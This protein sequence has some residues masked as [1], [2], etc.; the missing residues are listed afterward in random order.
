[1]E[2]EP[3]LTE[4][5]NI[6]L[7]PAGMG[8]SL[9]AARERLAMS[10][11]QAARALHLPKKIVIALEE[12]D[13]EALP[14]PA[15]VK[16]YLRAYARVLEI[17]EQRLIEQYLALG[18]RDPEL[19]VFMPR[20]EGAPNRI[21]VGL[22]AA[23]VALVSV[24]L[25]AVWWNTQQREFTEVA[26]VDEPTSEAGE[27]QTAE[28]AAS[29]EQLA[30]ARQRQ[31]E[32]EF[33]RGRTMRGGIAGHGEITQ[34]RDVA[35]SSNIAQN[36]DV[37]NG[38]DTPPP[39]GAPDTPR[40]DNATT[41]KPAQAPTSSVVATAA[42]DNSPPRPGSA[43]ATEAQSAEAA[44]T[45]QDKLG[46]RYRND[47]WTEVEDANGKQLL[48]GMV[49]AGE[50]HRVAGEAPFEVLLG[51]SRGV[52]LTINGEAFDPSPYVRAN[53]TARFTVDTTTGE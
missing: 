52:Q 21:S 10:R 7:Q 46:L 2:P 43:E 11:E 22:S 37:T 8:A 35:Q 39:P 48:Y 42:P 30:S 9:T 3:E 44:A 6:V 20:K 49:S 24:V 18:P 26:S 32:R 15:Y 47:S 38:R 19:T 50:A 31:S 29:D 53:N 5:E 4:P 13:H 28:N 51:S 23:V 25:S 41:P 33:G 14:A 12:E 27:S 16:G 36:G 34:S 45:A 1:M 40:Q 17:D